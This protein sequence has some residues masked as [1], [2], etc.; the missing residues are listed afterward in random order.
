MTSEGRRR[1][2]FEPQAFSGFISGRPPSPLT[3]NPRRPARAIVAP[4][5]ENADRPSS[6]RPLNSA[7]IF[8]HYT[9]TTQ[10]PL[11]R[12]QV[13]VGHDRRDRAAPGTGQPRRSRDRRPSSGDRR[14]GRAPRA[15]DGA[16]RSASSGVRRLVRGFS[17]KRLDVGDRVVRRRPALLQTADSRTTSLFASLWRRPTSAGA[18]RRCGV[19]IGDWH[20]A[21]ISAWTWARRPRAV[22]GAQVFSSR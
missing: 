7:P 9:G 8:D 11:A 2:G 20:R 19:Q 14:R 18:G 1:R 6:T 16:S 15:Q 21:R 17:R 10:A 5:V 4:G 3:G 12:L 22:L 13:D